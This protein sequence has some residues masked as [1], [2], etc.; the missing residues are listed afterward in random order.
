MDQ[1]FHCNFFAAFFLNFKHKW[2]IRGDY[3]VKLEV[4]ARKF[5]RDNM[6]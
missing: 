3:K 6:F 4:N 5:I 1:V 2:P